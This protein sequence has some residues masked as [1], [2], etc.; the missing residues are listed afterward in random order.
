V[1]LI[2]QLIKKL[3][4]M[5]NKKMEFKKSLSK[6]ALSLTLVFGSITAVHAAV[7]SAGS[8]IGNQ[9]TAS[10]TDGSGQSK[11]ATS[12]LVETT[13]AKIAG[14]S[15]VSPQSKT[16]SVGGT[17]L[18]QHT[19]TNTGNGIDSFALT[20]AD[21]NSGNIN[22]SAM[23]LYAD[24]DQ[25]GV[26]DS[27]TPI[28][29]TP[30]IASGASYG[31]IISATIPNGSTGGDS[32]TISLSAVSS[33]DGAVTI[34]NTDTVNVTGNAVVD[35]TKS[36]STSTGPS[37][38]IGSVQVTLTYTNTGDSTATGIIFND[39][40]PA[41]MTYVAGSG[42]WSGT[43]SALTDV[44]DGDEGG[45]N[46]TITGNTVT[47]TVGSIA[48]GASGTLTF[49]VN[50]NASVAPGD[51]TNTATITYDDGSGSTVGPVG[52]NGATYTVL[53]TAGLT[54][55]DKDSLS[56]EDT[57]VNDIVSITTPVAQGST[58]TFENK[59][60]NDGNGS[61]TFEI[62]IAA[63]GN[64]FPAGTVFQFF[65][66][67][68]ATP[69]SDTNADGSPD[70][71]LIAASSEEKIVVKAIL[72]S[73]FS[74]VAGYEFFTEATSK[75]NG[76]IVDTVSN[77]LAQIL[78]STVDVTNDTSVSGGAN[79]ADGLGAGAEASP[80]RTISVNPS[81]LATFSLFVNNTSVIP[82][83][84]DLE[85][86]TDPSFITKIVPT[87]WTVNFK[88]G[89][90]NVSDT[91]SI[92]ANGNKSLTV[93][94][95]VPADAV[96]SNTEL[97]FRVISQISGA[98]DIIHDRVTVNSVNDLS[99]TPNNTGQI[100]PAG[101]S[102]YTHVVNNSGNQTETSGVI[103]VTNNVALWNAIVYHD[104]NGDGL[105]DG[106]D[107]VVNNISDIAGGIAPNASFTLL[108][109]VFAPAGTTEGVVNTSTLSISG[110]SGET[111]LS[112][113]SANDVS[114][115]IE[116]DVT[117]QKKQGIDADCNGVVDGS[118]TTAQITNVLPGSCVVYEIIATNTGSAAVTTLVI[119]DT[120]PSFT[121]YFDCSSSCSASATSGAVS[122]PI[123]GSTGV[124][125]V[126]VG[127][128]SPTS[129][130]TLTFTVKIDQ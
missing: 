5:E 117:L 101:T 87:N 38:S 60:I 80:V 27:G 92:S 9:A 102:V 118:F 96:P 44:A 77:Q 21:L 30:N 90:S 41:G 8:V 82:D 73:S 104:A 35:V 59:V 109:K 20:A 31:V 1:I 64:T 39:I 106:G 110:V 24:A 100:F 49:D 81:Q 13:V 58:V 22:F 52:T 50:V 98:V 85:V 129:T 63:A 29:V 121:T 28:T 84:Y 76:S 99:I 88:D 127:G 14:V 37:P 115:V 16:V 10:Y 51:I 15:M 103:A 112:D 130:S 65:K 36:L 69:L 12:N 94:V 68:G 95:L 119:N 125:S 74:G 33:F 62:K 56:D 97:Y 53:Q 72:P 25:N 91:G 32:E 66:S 54:L 71:G 123:N 17:V 124:V 122:N 6:I 47:G 126:N 45:I 46:Y 23:A 86:S 42:N 128:L 108:V 61:D 93:E 3:N 18:F 19:I 70:T 11:V 4:K 34:S 7:P 55:N 43:G 120:T 26:P 57:L 113:N 2:C 40:L 67:D 114:T 105:L 48:S 78:Q 107:P 83:T 111:N 116:G 75:F 89:A 79:A